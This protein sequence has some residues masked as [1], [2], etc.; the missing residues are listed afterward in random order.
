[1]A[2]CYYSYY[3][4][5]T[6]DPGYLRKGADKARIERALKRYPYD[7]IMFAKGAWCDTC[8]LPKPARSKHCSLCNACCEKFD[9]HCVWVNACV[10]LHNYKWFILFLLLHSMICIYGLV[11]GYYIA[12]H[13]ID[14]G[15][16]W[17]KWYFNQQ[18]QKFR[19]TTMI[20]IQYLNSVYEMFSIVVFLCAIVTFMLL[21]FLFYHT[22]L[23]KVDRTTNEQV[24]AV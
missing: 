23:V 12:C 21:A 22:Y 4:A 15:D 9:H 14:E 17:N 20:L 10:G 8:D 16:L 18:G 19:A 7:N 3:K 1:M 13:L 24:K 11:I 5:C 2:S 6:T